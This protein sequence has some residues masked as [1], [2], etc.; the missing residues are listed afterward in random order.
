MTDV[1]I[2]KAFEMRVHGCSY[3]AIADA[4][5]STKQN[6][7]RALF[8]ALKE[9]A[10]YCKRGPKIRS[11]YPAISEW[12]NNHGVTVLQFSE[13]IGIGYRTLW[14]RL[15]G[16]SSFRQNEIIKLLDCT[17]LT[18]GDIFCKGIEG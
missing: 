6:V 9:R 1:D 10:P 15:H 14:N 12:M 18:F 13:K 8:R 4:M 11:I 16:K 7:Y 3:Q 2:I 17:G 5:G